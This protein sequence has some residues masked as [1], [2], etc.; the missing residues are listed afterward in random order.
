MRQQLVRFF[1]RLGGLHVARLAFLGYLSYIA[2]GW[3]FLC[4]PWAGKGKPVSTLDHLFIATSAVSTTGLVTVSV[5][6]RYTLFGQIV[7]LLLI[8]LGGIGYMTLGS[9]VI[10]S[11]RGEL[12]EVRA[13][14]G[15]TVFSLPASF[16][17]DKFILSVIRFTLVIEFLGAIALY[18]AF[19][20]A[21]VNEPLWSAVFHSV[22]A[23]CTAG[24]SLYNNSFEAFAADFWLNAVVAVL[25]Y[26]GAIGFIVC[27]DLW[28][29]VRGKVNHMTL[30]SKIILWTTFWLSVIGT[31]LLF[32]GEPS[33][34]GRPAGERLLAAFFQTMTAMTTVGFNTVPIAGLSKAS[35]LLIIVLMVIGASPSGTGGGIKS[36]TFSAVLGVMR[37]ALRGE[38]EVRFWGKPIPLERIWIA[39][40]SL[41]FYLAALVI[42]TYLLDMT[43]PTPFD[44]NFFEAA[45]ALGTVGLSTGIT[46]GLTDLGKLILILLMFIGRLGP[47]TFGMALFF[48][49][50]PVGGSSDSDLAI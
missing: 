18:A 24:F 43:E 8:Q 33:L 40:A 50:A 6:D 12:P 31:A 10:L 26:L 46:D 22:S 20:R 29:M 23:F 34:Q 25:S 11:R 28:R 27:V 15:R 3:V 13:K 9:F 48:R 45:S 5:A 44:R 39:V 14:V 37:S 38:H 36:T 4:L 35:I 7:V 41:G 21:G 16:R 1:R 49:T 19:R 2:A 30:T 42:G 32:L 47:L 17:I